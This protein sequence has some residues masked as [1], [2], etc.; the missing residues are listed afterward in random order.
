[1]SPQDLAHLRPKTRAWVR[2]ICKEFVLE[3][4]HERV[5]LVAASSW[6]RMLEAREKIAVEGL[7]YEDDKGVRRP[8]PAIKI[9]ADSQVR[10]MRAVRELDLDINE[11]PA[12]RLPAIRSNR[13]LKAIRGG[14]HAA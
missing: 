12:S 11:P 2:Q 7:T 13:T 9:E 3:S 14:G 8:N 4:H 1:M 6:D 10:F 5:L